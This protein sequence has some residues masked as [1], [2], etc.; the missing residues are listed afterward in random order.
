MTGY[1]V[2]VPCVRF[3][4]LLAWF[5]CWIDWLANVQRFNFWG[6][7]FSC[8]CFDKRDFLPPTTL[9]SSLSC[10]A[11]KSL[12]TETSKRFTQRCAID[13]KLRF[14]GIDTRKAH[15]KFR[16]VDFGAKHP[17]VNRSSSGSTKSDQRCQW[18]S[19]WR[20]GI[21]SMH[22]NFFFAEKLL[23]RFHRSSSFSG[24]VPLRTTNKTTIDQ[25]S[26]HQS[27][28]KDKTNQT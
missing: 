11:V 27:T 12:F 21:S 25:K 18:S 9:R 16:N 8:C 5:C 13:R 20:G 10:E 15:N 14:G 17:K 7:C 24:C 6:S 19:T 3:C 1:S 28:T 4:L 26:Q 23:H 22:W 2:V